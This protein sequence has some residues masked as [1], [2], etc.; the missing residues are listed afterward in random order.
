MKRGPR[1]VVGLSGMDQERMTKVDVPGPASRICLR[2]IVRSR[3]KLWSKSGPGRTFFSERVDH[4]RDGQ[5][6]PDPD[7]SRA[8]LELHVC[9]Q[10]KSQ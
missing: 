6:R 7:P 8:V 4:S 9:K 10:I 1:P 2:G 3:H 5:V